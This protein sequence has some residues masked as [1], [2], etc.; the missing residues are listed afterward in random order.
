MSSATS[1]ILLPFPV[2]PSFSFSFLYFIKQALHQLS[3]N[4]RHDSVAFRV[5]IKV[6]ARST[7]AITISSNVNIF[8][9]SRFLRDRKTGNSTLFWLYEL[10]VRVKDSEN[11]TRINLLVWMTLA[12]VGRRKRSWNMWSLHTCMLVTINYDYIIINYSNINHYW[13]CNTSGWW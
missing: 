6:S 2:K 3:Q 4:P 5:V 12:A 1:K 7:P 11:V 13:R 10:N 9:I 8:S